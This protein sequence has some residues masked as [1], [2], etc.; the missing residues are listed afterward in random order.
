M[1]YGSTNVPGASDADV[2]AAMAAAAEA[3]AAAQG[4]SDKLGATGDTGGSASAGTVFGKLNKIISDLVT[5]MG[6]WTATRAGYIDTIKTDVEAA[7]ADVAAIKA[8]MDGGTAKMGAVKSIQRG[9]ITQIPLIVDERTIRFSGEFNIPINIVN[10][11]KCLILLNT[12]AQKLSVASLNQ[13]NS[14]QLGDCYIDFK[15]INEDSITVKINRLLP[16]S[17]YTASTVE[18]ANNAY[19]VMEKP[20][21]WQVIEFY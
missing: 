7:K 11:N 17:S 8:T 10:K 16:L 13:S 19:S 15:D 6:R 3:Q 2:K 20:V 18:W 5:H 12:E 21:F 9:I 1:A 14:W 4:V